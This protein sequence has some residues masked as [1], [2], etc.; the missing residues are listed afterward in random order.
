M[1]LTALQT[2]ITTGERIIYGAMAIGIALLALLAATELAGAWF[3]A[4]VAY[5]AGK[6]AGRQEARTA[7][8]A[9]ARRIASQA[10]DWER[11]AD[12]ALNAAHDHDVADERLL[13]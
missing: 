13:P 8:R 1:S 12:D 7:N 2:A 9:R 10:E 6:A 3:A 11:W 5:R 4:K